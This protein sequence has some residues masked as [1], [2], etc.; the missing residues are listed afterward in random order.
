MHNFKAVFLGT[1]T[2][3]SS[4]SSTFVLTVTSAPPPNPTTTVINKKTTNFGAYALTGTVT[5]VGSTTP[6][7]GTISFLDINNGNAVLG[8]ATLPTPSLGWTTVDSQSLAVGQNTVALAK[9]DFNGDGLPDIAVANQNNSVSIL[10]GGINGIFTVSTVPLSFSPFSIA[11][12]DFNGDGFD[13]VGVGNFG[14]TLTETRPRA[15][16]LGK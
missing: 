16:V 1:K 12:A 4:S 10:L 15:C 3:A 7:S 2:Y 11:V 6:L 14:G 13:D 9:G 8:S 5:E